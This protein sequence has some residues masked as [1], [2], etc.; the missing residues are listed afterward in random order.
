MRSG[1]IAQCGPDRSRN[2]PRAAAPA[3]DLLLGVGVAIAVVGPFRRALVVGLA[4]RGAGAVRLALGRERVVVRVRREVA[5]LGVVDQAL[6]RLL[7]AL[8]LAAAGLAD[9]PHRG[10]VLI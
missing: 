5:V 8:R 2:A 3:G 4:V 1:S 9:G 7:E 10:A 6:L